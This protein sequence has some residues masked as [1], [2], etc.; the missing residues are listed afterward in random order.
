M[1]FRDFRQ[2]AAQELGVAPERQRWWRWARR[3]NGTLRPSAVLAE[4][5][6]ALTVMDLARVRAAPAAPLW[7]ASPPQGWRAGHRGNFQWPLGAS[8]GCSLDPPPLCGSVKGSVR[9][10]DALTGTSRAWVTDQTLYGI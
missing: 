6:D 2:L 3:Q 1:L 8:P 10:D 7:P 5:D 4:V 9:V